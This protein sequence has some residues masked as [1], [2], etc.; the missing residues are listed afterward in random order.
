MG[1]ARR[2]RTPVVIGRPKNTGL[3]AFFATRA[4]FA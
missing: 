2:R 3:V 1:A 4:S